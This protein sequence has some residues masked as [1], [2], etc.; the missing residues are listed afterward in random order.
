[1]KIYSHDNL[2]LHRPLPYFSYGKMQQPLEVPERMTE[3]LKAPAALGLTVTTATDIG[4]APILAVHDFGYIEFLQ[5]SYHE[6]MALDE[7]LGVQVQTGIYVPYNNPGLGIMAKAAKY[8]ADDSAPINEHSWT[9]IYWSAQ[10]ALS[11]ADALLN[12][13]SAASKVQL[14]FSRPPGHHARK[15]AAGGFCYINNAA[16]ITEY[17]RQKYRRIAII[18]TD[19][20]H[21]Q[22]IQEIFYERK[23]VLYTSVHGSPINFYPAVTGHEFEKGTGAGEGYNINFP[24]PHGS[25]EAE[26][27]AYV[28]QSIAAVKLFDPEVL[29]HV[30]GFDVYKDDPEARCQVST[31]GFKILAQKLKVL[32]KPLIVLVEGGYYLP[33]LNDNLQ[34]FLSGLI[35]E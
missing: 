12:D 9:S 22:G 10:T 32:D 11:A 19:M 8:Q 25:S 28:E 15:S 16:V 2:S 33:K 1:M 26:F 18:D 7:D 27:F 31:E 34:A 30:L 5:N 17:L 3:L 29:I 4:M 21:G 13:A 24:M 14:C 20:H 35:A 6:W 23:D